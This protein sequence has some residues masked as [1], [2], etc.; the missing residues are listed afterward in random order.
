MAFPSALGYS[1]PGANLQ[2]NPIHGGVFHSL[3]PLLTR[4]IRVGF[5]SDYLYQHSVGKMCAKLIA[6]LP[7]HLFHV[8]IFRFFGP[9]DWV[10]RFIDHAADEVVTLPESQTA[11]SLQQYVW[12][13]FVV[14]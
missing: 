6:A 7:R 13:E 14:G 3:P 10:S 1:I 9:S 11:A 2:N 12:T 4:H 8:T 5:V